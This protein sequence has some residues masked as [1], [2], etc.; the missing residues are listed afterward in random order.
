MAEKNKNKDNDLRP[1]ID[2]NE[3]NAPSECQACG[4]RLKFEKVNLEDYQ[5]GKL[6]MM[7]GVPAYVCQNCGENWIPEPILEEFENMI[8]AAKRRAKE[9]KVKKGKKE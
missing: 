8:E 5:G 1:A 3:E 9:K 6:Y 4:G 2:D 7:E